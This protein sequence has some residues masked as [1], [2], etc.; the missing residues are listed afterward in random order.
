[1]MVQSIEQVF[2]RFQALQ[3]NSVQLTPIFHIGVNDCCVT[4]NCSLPQIAK[5]KKQKASI[6]QLASD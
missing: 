3:L 1:M 2:V 6:R 5:S 4:A